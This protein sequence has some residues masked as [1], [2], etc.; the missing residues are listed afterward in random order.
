M[1][2]QTTLAPLIL[3]V[4]MARPASAADPAAGV[5]RAIQKVND[6]WIEAMK[7]ADAGPIGASFDPEGVNVA[8]DGS[9]QKGSQE[10]ARSFQEYL[11]RS[12]PAVSGSVRIGA[13]HI[14]GNLAYEW[15]H[16]DFR[17]AP[18]PGGPTART[19]RYLTAW[20]RQADG[21]WKILRNIGLPE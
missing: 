3:A 1:R 8:R 4:S 12:G 18:K 16:S 17:F 11:D 9:C 14:D 5:R 20:R 21:S 13:V 7:R 15:G 10:I 6:S 19:G 2:L